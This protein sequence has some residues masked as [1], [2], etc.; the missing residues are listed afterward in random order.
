MERAVRRALPAYVSTY[1]PEAYQ[2]RTVEYVD[3]MPNDVDV[4]E[5]GNEINGEWLGDT[6]SVVAKMT[7]AFDY[8]KKSEK[9]TAL[10]LYYN[11]GCF[12]NADHEMFTWATA[13]VP[14]SMKDGLDYVLVSYYE[15]DCNGLQPNWPQVFTRLAAMFPNSKVGFGECGTTIAARK[16]E[17]VHRY[18]KM[19][20][21]LP[22]LTFRN[23]SEATFDG[24]ID[25]VWCLTPIRFGS[26]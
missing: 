19:R 16:E 25:R 15:D 22:R 10:T 13:N 17:Y 14:Q 11:Q 1:T 23:T 4:W 18:Y 12:D 24:G 21:D 20:I 5:I 6:A 7:G 9:V 26:S 3:A 2:A 8:L